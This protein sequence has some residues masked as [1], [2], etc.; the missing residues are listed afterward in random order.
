MYKGTTTDNLQPD[1]ELS[2]QE[3]NT[4]SAEALIEQGNMRTTR[5]G[6]H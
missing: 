2:Q 1:P 4:T 5:K 6:D 3:F